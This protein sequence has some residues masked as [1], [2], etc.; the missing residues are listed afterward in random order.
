MSENH[1]LI[2]YGKLNRKIGFIEGIY[3]VRKKSRIHVNNDALFEQAGVYITEKQNL[4][5]RMGPELIL[6]LKKQLDRLE[7]I[8]LEIQDKCK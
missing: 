6:I 5:A 2:D 8:C 4:E 3:A 1:P 7:A